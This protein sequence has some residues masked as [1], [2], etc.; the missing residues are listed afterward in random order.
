[1]GL[2]D[3]NKL[4]NASLNVELPTLYPAKLQLTSQNGHFEDVLMAIQSLS[5]SSGWQMYR[6]ETCTGV[7]PMQRKDLIEA[8]YTNGQDSIHIKLVGKQFRIS[9]F[10]A[11][12]ANLDTQWVYKKQSMYLSNK[13]LQDKAVFHIWYKQSSESKWEPVAQQFI[14]FYD[15]ENQ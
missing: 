7:E 14:G 6:D 13:V 10:I 11:S 3:Y 15:E 5:P 2:E 8:Q 4:Q 1:M 9:S 12:E